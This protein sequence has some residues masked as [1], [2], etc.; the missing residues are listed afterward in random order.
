[1][2]NDHI[3]WVFSSAAQSISAFV[4]FLLTGY[5]LVHTIMEAAREK[6]DTLD[7]IHAALRKKYHTRLTLLTWVTGVAI[8]LSLIIVFANRWDFTAKIWLMG[9]TTAVDLA[10]I[11]G[12]MAFV[13][14]IVNPTKYE[15]AAE[16]VLEEKKYEMSLSGETTSSAAFFEEFRHLE[17]LIREY[18]QQKDL[19]IPSKGGPR[20]HLSFRQMI[21]A[22]VQ[23]ERIDSSFLEELIQINK[24]RNLVFH[25]HVDNADRTMVDRVR[26]ATSRIQNLQ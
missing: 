20:M 26:A 5:A 6:D 15:R 16:K 17:R 21:E 12:G 19:Y 2:N 14:S 23:N 22:L 4:A 10:A 11:I 8:I 1:M 7:E 25:G 18:L 13:V 9:L 24:Y 3:Y